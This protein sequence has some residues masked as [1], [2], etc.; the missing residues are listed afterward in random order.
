MG[1]HLE[2]D[3]AEGAALSDAA[4]LQQSLDSVIPKLARCAGHERRTSPRGRME[5][6]IQIVPL[7]DLGNP[8]QNRVVQALSTTL[9][10]SGISFRHRQR[11]AFR[12]AIVEFHDRRLG[13][14]RVEISVGW[15]RLVEPGCYESGGRLVRTALGHCLTTA[16][17]QGSD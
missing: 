10:R 2:P 14:F 16:C 12:S 8:L 4:E 1:Q 7:D 3:T 15:T 9:S 5:T 11:F 13:H 17:S 6:P